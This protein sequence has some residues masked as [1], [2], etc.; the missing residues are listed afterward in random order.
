MEFLEVIEQLAPVRALR[1]SFYA[2][3]LVN[4]AHILLIG[5]LLTSVILMDLRIL[6]LFPSQDR[7]PFLRL[8]RGL[9]LTAFCGAAASGLSLFAVRA[10]EYAFNP[11]FRLK[12]L[13]ILLAGLNLLALRLWNSDAE[14]LPGAGPA[15]RASALFS[16]L[17]WMGVLVCGRFIGFL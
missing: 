11:A 15:A 2:Y 12:M 8:M 6:G 4:A 10:G 1:M 17:L 14:G 5:V 7:R 13:L 16:I 3:P 9:A